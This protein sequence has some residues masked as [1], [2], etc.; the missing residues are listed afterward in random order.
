ME[1]FA[2]TASRG[3]PLRKVFMSARGYVAFVLKTGPSPET[4]GGG[5]SRVAPLSPA[6][7]S[8]VA[9]KLNH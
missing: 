5:L 7:K 6:L 4:R 9:Q 8:L 3:G 1:H 2:K